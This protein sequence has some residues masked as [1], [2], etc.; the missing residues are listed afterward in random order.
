MAQERS[1]LWKS[2]WRQKNTKK[3]YAFKIDGVW[4]GSDKEIEHSYESGLYESF[5]IGNATSAVLNLRLYAEN[6]PRGAKIERFMR[7]VNGDEASEWLPK[8]NYGSYG[9]QCDGRGE[10]TSSDADAGDLSP[11]WGR[12]KSHRAIYGSYRNDSYVFLST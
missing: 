7:L 12:G 5:G 11:V 1:A 9:V 2:L 6:I 10:E 4:Y 3:E 8:G